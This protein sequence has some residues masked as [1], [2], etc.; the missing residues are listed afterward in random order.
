VVELKNSKQAQS[1]PSPFG[2][3]NIVLNGKLVADHPISNTRFV[4][5]MKKEL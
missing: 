4:N 5:I 1:A 3:F 2:I